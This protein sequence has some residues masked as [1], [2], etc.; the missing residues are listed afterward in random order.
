M[1]ELLGVLFLVHGISL[2][3]CLFDPIGTYI[4]LPLLNYSIMFVPGQKR[5]ENHVKINDLT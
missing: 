5:T 3:A 1:M 2:A 4:I